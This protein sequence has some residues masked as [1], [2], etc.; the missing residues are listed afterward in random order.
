MSAGVSVQDSDPQAALDDFD[1]ARKLNPLSEQ[2]D[3]LAGTL[4][5][6]EG[7]LSG[8]RSAFL[9]AQDRTARDAYAALELGAIASAQGNRAEAIVLLRR[10]LAL[11]P[12][13]RIARATLERVRKGG[14]INVQV[15]NE[16]LQRR[17]R[18][19]TE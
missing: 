7:D 18:R 13:D 19:A 2:P 9:R 10:A 1:R 5:V 17:A 8:A 6:R 15:L 3:L 16:A 11:N 14:R 12:R 4:L